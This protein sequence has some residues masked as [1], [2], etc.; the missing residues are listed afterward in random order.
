MYKK[1]SWIVKEWKKL[2]RTIWFPTANIEINE[3]IVPWTYKVNVYY[4]EKIYSWVWAILENSNIFETHIFDFSENI[5]KENIEVYILGKIRENK[6]FLSLED[7]KEQIKEDII[8]AKSNKS[9]VLTF[10]TFDL[11]HK[12]HLYFLNEAKKY[13]NELITVIARD[14]NVEK[15]KWFLPNFNEEK[16][17]KDIENANIS[18]KVL[19]WKMENHLSFLDDFKPNLICLWYDQIW[20]SS[21]LENYIQ[22]K[23]LNTKV[24]RINSFKPEEFK[25]SILRKKII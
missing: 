23:K 21:N 5:Y 11:F 12:G 6:K 3:H 25:S 16:R 17:Q 7:L 1:I 14:K 9:I 15:I 13:S 10:W 20:F 2:W 4:K 24:I 22:E 8:F 19:L 18:N